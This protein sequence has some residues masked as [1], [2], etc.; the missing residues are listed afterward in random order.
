[1]IK[2]AKIANIAS[3]IGT[4]LIWNGVSES[5]GRRITQPSAFCL[6]PSAFCDKNGRKG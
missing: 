6:L 2:N 1:M 4:I 5:S 3:I